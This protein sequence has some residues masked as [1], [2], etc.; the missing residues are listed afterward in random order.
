[1][2]QAALDDVRN[3]VGWFNSLRAFSS[4]SNISRRSSTYES[5]V[6][7]PIIIVVGWVALGAFGLRT[8]TLSR[9]IWRLT[10]TQSHIINIY[11]YRSKINLIYTAPKHIVT[12]GDHISCHEISRLS[13][14]RSS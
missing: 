4:P 11:N 10:A 7:T 1:V 8:V 6:A 12:C 3:W 13:G 2:G 14:H 5:A 9:V